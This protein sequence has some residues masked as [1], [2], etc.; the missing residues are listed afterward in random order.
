MRAAK[1][2]AICQP[3]VY[4]NDPKEMRVRKLNEQINELSTSFILHVYICF[5]QQIAKALWWYYFSKFIEF[6]DTVSYLLSG[7]IMYHLASVTI[8]YDYDNPLPNTGFLYPTQEEQ[9]GVLPA[10]LPSCLHV[11]PLV[12]WN[13]VGSWRPM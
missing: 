2:N 4:S 3:I 13:Q 1:Y 10:C 6:F 7:F 12:D 5:V 8:V 11:L 9:P